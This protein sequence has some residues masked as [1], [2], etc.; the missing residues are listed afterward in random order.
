M[1]R[2]E[3]KTYPRLRTAKT[4]STLGALGKISEKANFS[5]SS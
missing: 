1:S 2:F 3:V 4:S 5:E